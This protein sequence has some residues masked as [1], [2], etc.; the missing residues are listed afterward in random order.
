M[1][2]LDNLCPSPFHELP[3]AQRARV[4]NRLGDTEL[5]VAL[6]ADPV[7]DRVRIR[8]FDLPQGRLAIAADEE[9]RVA[10]FFDAPT[11]HVAMPGRALAAMLA[12]KVPPGPRTA[13][14]LTGGNTD[15][16]SFAE[17]LARG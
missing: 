11:G 1:T 13:V 15:P 6:D 14:M 5:F 2:P 10:A 12:G 8:L 4:L 17:V 9:D 16:A 7:G 3:D